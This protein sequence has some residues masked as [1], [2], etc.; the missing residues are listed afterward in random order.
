MLPL[1]TLLRLDLVEASPILI[2]TETTRSYL[3]DR[4]GLVIQVARFISS[5]AAQAW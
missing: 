2:E 5:M 1:P 3:F 4:L